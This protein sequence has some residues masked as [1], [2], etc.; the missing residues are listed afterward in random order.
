MTRVVFKYILLA[1]VVAGAITSSCLRKDSQKSELL[2]VLAKVGDKRL[3]I[4]D[5]EGIF[6]QGISQEDSLKLLTATVESW[7]KDQLKVQ[8]AQSL[9][10]NQ[11]NKIDKEVEQY[12]NKLL[13]HQSEQHYI[14]THVDTVVTDSQIEFFY[15][16]STTEFTLLSPIIRCC[17]LSFPT[18]FRQGKKLVELFKSKRESDWLDL[19]DMADKNSLMLESFDSWTEVAYIKTLLPEGAITSFGSYVGKKK[20]IYETSDKRNRYLVRVD[21][22][23][24]AGNKRPLEQVRGIIRQMIIRQR[25][26][27]ELK[28]LEDS[29]LQS[30]EREGAIF[31]N[32]PKDKQLKNKK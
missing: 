16:N 8:Y 27:N 19:V 2:G 12:R 25:A 11:S 28:F 13:I 26:Q 20:N 7:V 3:V 4:E 31:V 14:N 24:D 9:K 6:P 29:L 1:C 21:Q 10:L 30:A 22:F 5:L 32:Q 17:I 23:I 18:D 15:S